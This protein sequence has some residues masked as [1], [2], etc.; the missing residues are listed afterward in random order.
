MTDKPIPLPAA[1]V[2]EALAKPGILPFYQDVACKLL[3]A[4][5]LVE[6][7]LASVDTRKTQVEALAAMRS[8]HRILSDLGEAAI[9]D[10]LVMA[11]IVRE[12]T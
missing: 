4:A 8:G 6:P 10:R 12:D 11:G 7:E 9:L 2:R 1:L 3:A 5:G